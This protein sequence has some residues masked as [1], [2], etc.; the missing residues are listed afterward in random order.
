MARRSIL[1]RHS[2]CPQRERSPSRSCQLKVPS[3]LT[4]SPGREA[5]RRP[6][7]SSS[8]T[9]ATSSSPRSCYRGCT[10][11]T[12]LSLS[13]ESSGEPAEELRELKLNDEPLDPSASLPSSGTLQVVYFSTLQQDTITFD[14]SLD[15][16]QP[17]DKAICLRL[18]ERALTT[19]TGARTSLSLTLSLSPHPHPSLTT[20]TDD[21]DAAALDGNNTTFD[22]WMYPHVPEAGALAIT[23]SVRLAIKPYDRGVFFSPAMTTAAFE[24]LMLT[25]E[26]KTPGPERSIRPGVHPPPADFDKVSLIKQAATRNYFTSGQVKSLLDVISGRKNKIE[27]AVL[28]YSRT[29][30]QANFQ[31]ALKSIGQDQDRQDILE[32]VGASIKR[33]MRKD[34]KAASQA[35]AATSAVS[36]LALASKKA[37]AEEEEEEERRG[38]P[39][40][41]GELIGERE[42]GGGVR[43][44]AGTRR[45]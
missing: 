41:R 20:P 26:G 6:S 31:H 29:T 12:P 18:W 44:C 34:M 19:P 4:T 37:A 40:A 5:S 36:A 38:G 3:S 13:A 1:M 11:D 28:A 33:K 30:D 32:M 10:Q 8:P 21:W 39:S 15:L 25:L 43:L 7:G 14:V 17:N 42:G 24:R 27:T 2:R 22:S 35:A 23:Y 9:R 45:R 16:S